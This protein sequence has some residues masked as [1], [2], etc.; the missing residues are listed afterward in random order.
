MIPS[1]FRY[2]REGERQRESRVISRNLKFGGG[3]GIDKCLGGV[4]LCEAQIYIKDI[5]ELF[6][7][8]ESGGWVSFLDGGEVFTPLVGV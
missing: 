7:Y 2:Y 3:G 6:L 8:T 4:N 1:P 5:E